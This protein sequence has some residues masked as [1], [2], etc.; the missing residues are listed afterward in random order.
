MALRDGK[1]DFSRWKDLKQFTLLVKKNIHWKFVNTCHLN[2]IIYKMVD[3]LIALVSK[4]HLNGDYWKG[5]IKSWLKT[6]KIFAVFELLSKVRQIWTCLFNKKMS[7]QLL[8]IVIFGESATLLW[9]DLTLSD[10]I[11]VSLQPLGLISR[12]FSSNRL[13]A[14]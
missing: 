10:H 12:V 8:I 9:I 2:S 5:A 1:R 4:F 6:T 13:P 11:A 3:N 7:R 14:Y